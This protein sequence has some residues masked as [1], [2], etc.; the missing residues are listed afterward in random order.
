MRV[1]K[2]P[3]NLGKYFHELFCIQPSML[4]YEIGKV[5]SFD[6]IHHQ[7]W[8]LAFGDTKI[9]DGNQVFVSQSACCSRLYLEALQNFLISAEVFVHPFHCFQ[10]L[11]QTMLRFIHAPGAAASN[12]AD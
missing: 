1:T 7:I 4:F 9:S 8:L 6:I 3:T 2:T 12:L 10:A 11:E 5:F